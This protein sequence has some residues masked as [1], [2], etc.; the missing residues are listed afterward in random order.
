MLVN[1][2]R[3]QWYNQVFRKKD[4]PTDVLSFPVNEI[5][6]EGAHC[7]GDILISV[8][9]AA[10]QARAKRHSLDRELQILLLHGMLH[11]RGYD[12]ETDSGEMNRLES[13]IRKSV[14]NNRRWIRPDAGNRS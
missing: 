2:K 13:R 8:E 3:M 1:N 7:L 4:S 5:T 11:L 14:L 12:H 6:A 10:E 9:K